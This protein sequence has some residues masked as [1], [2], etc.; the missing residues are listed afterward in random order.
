[1]K[2]PVIATGLMMRTCLY[3]PKELAVIWGGHIHVHGTNEPNLKVLAGRCKF[4]KEDYSLTNT[5]YQSPCQGCFGI[6]DG[7]R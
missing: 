1:M 7:L 6:M 3:H 2:R 5:N 4:C